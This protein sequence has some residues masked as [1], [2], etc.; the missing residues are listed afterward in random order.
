MDTQRHLEIMNERINKI[1]K[2]LEEYN[3]PETPENIGKAWNG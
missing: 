1:R 2:K 3:I